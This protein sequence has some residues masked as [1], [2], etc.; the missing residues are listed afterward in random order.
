M[1]RLKI[2]TEEI[3]WLEKEA[4]SRGNTIFRLPC[5]LTVHD[6]FA[7]AY[8]ELRGQTDIDPAHL[9]GIAD[10]MYIYWR[11]EL[12]HSWAEAVHAK[13]GHSLLPLAE[14]L[15]D[16]VTLLDSDYGR[17]TELGDVWGDDDDI[18]LALAYTVAVI[19]WYSTVQAGRVAE[20]IPASVDDAA[21]WL[22]QYTAVPVAKNP[23]QMSL[24]LGG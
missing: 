22:A 20:V 16:R 5:G 18:A 24:F 1:T 13:H 14:T 4:Q 9:L 17:N 21:A 23:A 7:A 8:K 19:R 12:I 11:D 3:R 6:F 2:S 15:V 10:R